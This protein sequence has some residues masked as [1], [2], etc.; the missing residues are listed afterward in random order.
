MTAWRLLKP[1]SC[2]GV[3]PKQLKTVLTQEVKCGIGDIV[4]F[5]GFGAFLPS[6]GLSGS[7]LFRAILM[8][9]LGTRWSSCS[10]ASL[11]D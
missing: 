9:M 1:E 5:C 3:R 11:F 2:V 4:D 6:S 10:G 7:P 8:D